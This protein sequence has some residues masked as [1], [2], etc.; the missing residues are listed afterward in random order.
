MWGQRSY[1]NTCSLGDIWSSHEDN[2]GVEQCSLQ[3]H[4][5]LNQ[6]PFST[7]FHPW[8]QSISCMLISQGTGEFMGKWMCWLSD[9]MQFAP[10]PRA[11]G[12]ELWCRR[13]SLELCES[14]AYFDCSGHHHRAFIPKITWLTDLKNINLLQIPHNV[15]WLRFDD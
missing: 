2:E 14:I 8:G 13:Y 5:P 7:S 9:Y 1:Y 11:S 3:G 15:D 4:F 12:S 6:S 10:C